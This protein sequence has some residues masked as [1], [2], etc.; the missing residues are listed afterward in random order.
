MLPPGPD[1]SPRV[2]ELAALRRDPLRYFAELRRHGEVAHVA[3]RVAGALLVRITLVQDP[4]LIKKILVDDDA[5]FEKPRAL[6]KLK[7]LLGEGLLTSEGEHHRRQRRLMQPAFHRDAILRYAPTMVECAARTEARWQDGATLDMTAELMHVTLAIAGRTL[8]GVDV[9][10]EADEIGRALATLMEA[11]PDLISPFAGLWRVLPT[12]RNR[13]VAAALARIDETI[14]R[15][16]A[17]RRAADEPGDDLLGRLLAAKDEGKAGMTEQQVRDEAITLFLA[18]HE[19]TAVA[20]AWTFYLLA[21]HP[22]A[23]AAVHA[24]LDAVLAGRLPTADD[25]PRLVHTR[26]ALQEAMRLY[27]PA[28][29][30]GR[31]VLREY[32]LGPYTIPAGRSMVFIC[33]Y[34]L[35][36]DE[37]YFPAPLE[38][39]PERWTPEF[40]A[41]LPRFAY[42]PFGGGA[43]VCIGAAFAWMEGTLA[44]ATLLRRWTLELAPGAAVRPVPRVTLRPSELPMIVRLRRAP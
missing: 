31:G 4:A 15:I 1:R 5:W 27:P 26:R 20:L 42:V 7:L 17:A 40:E 9:T 44:L 8:F 2:W 3:V 10:A 39:R 16:I 29:T 33:P 25:L 6:K 18:G 35:H 34:L 24:E 23:L 38:F 19:T 22:E 41:G 13:A 43:R 14:F 28:H 30:F 11:F 21:G 37:R 12:R 32:A 36:R